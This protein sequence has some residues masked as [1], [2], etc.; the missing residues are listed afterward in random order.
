MI[1]YGI[2][3]EE[4]EKYKM[5]L[6]K[7]VE[8]VKTDIQTLSNNYYKSIVTNDTELFNTTVVDLNKYLGFN[9]IDI[10]EYLIYCLVIASNGI[11]KKICDV[12]SAYVP[13]KVDLQFR[14]AYTRKNENYIKESGLNDSEVEL[15]TQYIKEKHEIHCLTSAIDDNLTNKLKPKTNIPQELKKQIIVNTTYI[16]GEEIKRSGE[17]FFALDK[18]IERCSKQQEL[19]Q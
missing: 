5:L 2:A 14:T 8:D 17:I 13:E 4:I 7:P 18:C 15:L 9:I 19:Q 10:N 3:E 12:D 16:R 11:L 6:D 1:N